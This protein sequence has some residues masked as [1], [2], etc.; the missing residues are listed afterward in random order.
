MICGLFEHAIDHMFTRSGYTQCF[1]PNL[2]QHTSLHLH[3]FALTVAIPC[4]RDLAHSPFM[5]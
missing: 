1:R 2:F 5:L 3:L 4:I